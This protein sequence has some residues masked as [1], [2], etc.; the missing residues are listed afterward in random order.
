MKL[1]LMSVTASILLGCGQPR[2]FTIDV[3]TPPTRAGYFST[4][5][6]VSSGTSPFRSY[7]P[8]LSVEMHGNERTSDR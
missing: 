6:R 4:R 3:W 2:T 8:D 1:A 5:A 7:A